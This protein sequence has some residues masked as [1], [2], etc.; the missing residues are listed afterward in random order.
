VM[1]FYDKC[2]FFF[3]KK[4]GV[5][6]LVHDHENIVS[7]LDLIDTEAGIAMVLEVKMLCCCI[8]AF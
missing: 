8:Q 6:K 5:L 3:L 1:F 7:L 4:K 2:F